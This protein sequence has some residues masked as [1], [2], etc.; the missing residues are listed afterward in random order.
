M[1]GMV[2]FE[3][4]L[5]RYIRHV[6][7]CEGMDYVDHLNEPQGVERFTDE[8]VAALERLAGLE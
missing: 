8:E 7:M 2:D 1:S 4:V 6:R 3:D 5:R